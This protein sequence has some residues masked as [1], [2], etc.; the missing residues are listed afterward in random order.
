MNKTSSANF[1]VESFARL[2]KSESTHWWFRSRNEVVIWAIRKYV[3]HCVDFLEIGCGTGFVLEGISKS[4]QQFKLSGSEYFDEGLLFAKKRIPS[5]DFRQLDAT[6]M[7]DVEKYDCVG[8]FDVI[9]HIEDDKLVLSNINRSLKPGGFLVVTVPQ[10]RWLWSV[11]DEHAQHVRRYTKIELAKK[12]KEAGFEIVMSTSFVSLLV[13]LMWISRMK[14]QSKDNFD[15]MS[16]FNIPK[17]LNFLL[18]T[19]M[20]FELWL[21]KCGLSLPIGGSRILV[22]RKS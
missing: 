16:E 4:F 17:G 13:P 22:A 3:S 12:V 14:T 15:P 19:I 7:N 9:E 5:A 1:P 21:L 11:V 10:H 6:K 20:K 2:A 18:E 8:A